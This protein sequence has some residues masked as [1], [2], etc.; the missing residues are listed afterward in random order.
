MKVNEVRA[1]HCQKI[2][3]ELAGKNADYI[4]K[5]KGFMRQAFEQA[6]ENGISAHNPAAKLLC[7]KG[8][9]GR[10]SAITD[11]QR[12]LLLRACKE[13][14]Y[15]T[16]VLLMLYCGL[17]PGEGRL[18]REKDVDLKNKKLFINGTKTKA[19]K[20]YVP[21]PEKLCLRLRQALAEPFEMLLKDKH[22]NPITPGW[23][24]RVWAK[25]IADMDALDNAVHPVDK[26][27][28]AYCL[29][30]TFATD[31]MAA[32]VPIN[33]IKEWMGHTSIVITLNTYVHPAEDSFE[34]SRDLI[35]AFH[36]RKAG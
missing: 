4:R 19:A 2:L 8:Y 33:I 26:D 24:R 16:W 13:G 20:R 9:V 12:E 7:P 34:S 35:N 15:G 28:T 36:D 29:R 30:H 5:L 10:R 3:N 25:M 1:I 32:G 22:G 31:L 18:L 17:R 21:I 11:R 23:Q 27:F 14:E 6:V